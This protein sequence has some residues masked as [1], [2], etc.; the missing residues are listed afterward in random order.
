MDLKPFYYVRHGATEWNLEG[1]LQ[2]QQDIPLNEIGIQQAQ[3]IIQTIN[4]L[5][6][7]NVFYSPL[8]RAAQT[9]NMACN[10]LT[11]PKISLD[12]LK[13][14]DW[15][16]LEGTRERRAIG[17]MEETGYDGESTESYKARIVKGINY[18]LSHEGIP[19]IVAHGGT[20]HMLVSLLGVESQNI[21]NCEI[22]LFTPPSNSQN[23]WVVSKV[24]SN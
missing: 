24:L 22:L 4:T 12:D 17:R 5:P 3:D 18:A 19:L 13:E 23:K 20:Y 21:K 15:G 9:A 16:S 14:C 2:G 7:S 1:K 8:K 6:I 10:D 11:C